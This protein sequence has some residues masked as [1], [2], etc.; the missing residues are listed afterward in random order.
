MAQR[1]REEDYEDQPRDIVRTQS[2]FDHPNVEI[3]NKFFLPTLNN[4][5]VKNGYI[6]GNQVELVKL[7]VK[8]LKDMMLIAAGDVDAQT[9]LQIESMEWTADRLV[10]MARDGFGAKIPNTEYLQQTL[11][12]PGQKTQ[13]GFMSKLPVIGRMF[14]TKEKDVMDETRS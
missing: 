11:R 1:F 9:G 5:L 4:E 2:D 13:G 14:R 12:Q 3:L 6:P 10:E 7:D 8:I